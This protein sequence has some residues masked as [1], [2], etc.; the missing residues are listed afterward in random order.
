MDQV[1]LQELFNEYDG[2][3][4]GKLEIKELEALLVKLG[5]APMV[6]PL[7]RGSAS[8]DRASRAA[9]VEEAKN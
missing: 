4:D 7:K 5:V 2:N 9:I 1:K 6:D 3:K 8:T